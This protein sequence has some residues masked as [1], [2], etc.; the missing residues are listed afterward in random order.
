MSAAPQTDTLEDLETRS[1]D[2]V[3]KTPYV[4]PELAQEYKTRLLLGQRKILAKQNVIQ[5][6][7]L[8]IAQAKE[9]LKQ[10]EVE[11]GGLLNEITTVYKINVMTTSLDL[12]A[13]K[14]IPK[15]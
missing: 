10:A 6:A 2:D 15:A 3:V 5:T 14:L 11:F 8:T 7:Q 12:E 9:E 1:Q 4:Y 13:L